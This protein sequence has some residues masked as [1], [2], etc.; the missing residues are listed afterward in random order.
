M[1][2]GRSPVTILPQAADSWCGNGA[3]AASEL[4][5]EAGLS[6]L[7]GLGFLNAGHPCVG[8]SD[9]KHFDAYTPKGA[10]IPT[11]ALEGGCGR[12]VC[13]AEDEAGWAIEV[14]RDVL[15]FECVAEHLVTLRG[16]GRPLVGPGLDEDERVVVDTVDVDPSA[17]AEVDTAGQ[18]GE[19]E[20]GTEFTEDDG[21]GFP[22]R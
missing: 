14:G 21:F 16:L 22:L 2:A 5:E 3:K 15:Q 4:G 12:L 17:I 10:G 9:T 8:Q 11:R 19:S 6:E 7:A 13:E 18:Q 1:C 20:V